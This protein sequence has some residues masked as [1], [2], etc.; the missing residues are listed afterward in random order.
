MINNELKNYIETKIL[1]EYSNF[2]GGHD[3]R[4]IK[5]VIERSLKLYDALKHNYDLNESMIY[6]V[7][8]Y[9]DIG[10][11]ISRENHAKN[12]YD[13]LISDTNLKKWFNDDQ[14]ITMAEAVE[15]HSTSSQNE[16]RSIYGKIVCDADKDIDIKI[17]LLRGW[18][19]SLK[20]FPD[21]TFDERVSE[22]QKEI[23][24]RFGNEKIG[25]KNLV[26]FYFETKENLNFLNKMKQYASDINLLKEDYKM[27][28]NK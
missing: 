12:S 2:D 22:I 14:I 24:R 10:M 9:H 11:K 6:V 27:I 4:H 16:P 18:E 17:G 15:D 25:G 19:F 8:C 3:Q 28:L 5:A 21:L 13:I 7:A 20:N 1:P 23:I 26:K